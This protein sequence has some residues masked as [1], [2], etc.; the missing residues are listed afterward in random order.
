MSMYEVI[1][2]G[3]FRAVID[4]AADSREEAELLA[5]AELTRVADETGIELEVLSTEVNSI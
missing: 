3:K 2:K 4:V 1:I 5:E